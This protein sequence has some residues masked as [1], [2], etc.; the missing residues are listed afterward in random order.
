MVLRCHM[1]DQITICVCKTCESNKFHGESSNMV[2]EKL[3]VFYSA[4]VIL[5]HQPLSCLEIPVKGMLA[6]ISN[7]TKTMTHFQTYKDEAFTDCWNCER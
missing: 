5:W 1:K 3:F 6:S 4:W 7:T 2:L